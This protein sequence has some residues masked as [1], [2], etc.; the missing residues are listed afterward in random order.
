MDAFERYVRGGLERHGVTVD[1]TEIGIMRVVEQV[2]GAD[3][4]RLVAA[5]LHDHWPEPDLDPGRAPTA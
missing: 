4:Q 5:D 3:I 1:E 2:Y